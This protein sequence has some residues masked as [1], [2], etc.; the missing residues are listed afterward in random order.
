MYVYM[1]MYVLPVSHVSACSCTCACTYVSMTY[2]RI[3]ICVLGF[4]C[5][6]CV[7]P[8]MRATRAYIRTNNVAAHCATVARRR[9]YSGAMDPRHVRTYAH[10]FY[11]GLRV[12]CT[13][14]A[15]LVNQTVFRERACARER[16]RGG[17]KNTVWPNWPGFRGISY[18]ASRSRCDQ[19]DYGYAVII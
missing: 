13:R 3:Q 2:V 10:M 17:R 11:W 9:C 18:L 12:A 15:S 8:A 14:W 4:M 7:G 5:L 6:A 19:S 1:Y 16:G